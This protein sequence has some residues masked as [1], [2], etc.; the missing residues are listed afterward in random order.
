[1]DK[2]ALLSYLDAVPEGRDIGVL[3]F[4]IDTGIEIVASFDLTIEIS[5]YDEL[6]I[7]VFI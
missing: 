4:S 3:I 1:M 2:Q 5:Q 7:C 6:M